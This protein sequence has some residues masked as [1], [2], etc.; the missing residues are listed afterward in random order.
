ML[1]NEVCTS[2]N[3]T[4]YWSYWD[5][6]NGTW[7]LQGTILQLIYT[8][9]SVCGL[10]GKIWLLLY[11]FDENSHSLKQILA[12]ENKKSYIRYPSRKSLGLGQVFPATGS[13]WSGKRRANI[14]DVTVM[15][16]NSPEKAAAM[17]PF[18]RLW[19]RGRE[20]SAMFLILTSFCYR[21]FLFPSA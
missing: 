21:R 1:Y 11:P 6:I 19:H 18:C 9:I 17:L 8:N 4:L 10:E 5:K 3:E 14:S 16:Q 13:E 15:I 12:A 7:W 20:T 2:C